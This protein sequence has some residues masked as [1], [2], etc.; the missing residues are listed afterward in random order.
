MHI[1]KNPVFHK[2]AKHIEINCHFVREVLVS[3]DLILSYP[4]SNQQPMDIFTKA[5]VTMQFLHL[6][7]KLGMIKPHAPT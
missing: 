2:W 4:R 1:L 3:G 5:L 7:D 6:H